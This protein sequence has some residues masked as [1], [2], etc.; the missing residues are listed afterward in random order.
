MKYIR[1]RSSIYG[2][3]VYI[4]TI[5]SLILYLASYVSWRKWLNWSNLRTVFG[6]FFLLFVSQVILQVHI[7]NFVKERFAD[8]TSG[9][10]IIPV[11][12][13]GY[14]I[15]ESL[16]VLSKAT[17]FGHGLRT[18]VYLFLPWDEKMGYY[19]PLHS[20]YI[21][22]LHNLGVFG[23]LLFFTFVIIFMYYAYKLSRN[24][25]RGRAFFGQVALLSFFG[26]LVSSVVLA[27]VFHFN[28]SFFLGFTIAGVIQMMPARKKEM[29]A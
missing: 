27:F 2:R 14:R 5:L 22:I 25:N 3:V 10:A 19:Y 21:Q 7:T 20:L 23:L 18:P 6:V 29:V 26:T 28:S 17:F 11:T 9:E 16:Y 12:S 1:F 4:I 8:M 15:Y 13:G 24:P